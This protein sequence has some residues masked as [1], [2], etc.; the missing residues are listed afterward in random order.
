MTSRVGGKTQTNRGALALAIV[1]GNLARVEEIVEAYIALYQGNC[2]TVFV[3]KI[4]SM[5][6]LYFIG[7]D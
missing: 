5:L 2:L 6:T 3:G 4:S 1:E 7:I